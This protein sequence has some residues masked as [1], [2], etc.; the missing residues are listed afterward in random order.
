MAARPSAASAEPALNPNQPN[1]SRPA[2]EHDE[3]HVVRPVPLVPDP[4]R[5]QHPGRD[6]RRDAGADVHDRSAREVQGAKFGDPAPATPDPVR[7]RR[8]HDQ[9]PCADERRIRL[10]AH[11]SHH[12][13]GDQ[14]GVMI[15]NIIWKSMNTRCGMSSEYGPASAPTLRNPSQSSPPMI[16]LPGANAREEAHQRPLQGDQPEGDEA[17]L[18]RV[19]HAVLSHEAAVEEAQARRHQQ[20]QGGRREHPC[21]VSRTHRSTFRRGKRPRVG[22]PP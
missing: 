21:R 9:P 13:A 4:A 8:V 11:S 15:A 22:P 1:Q 7:E 12:G 14:R 17:H 10:E 18:D 20:D 6:E 2:P 19:H 5:A 3:R 16:A